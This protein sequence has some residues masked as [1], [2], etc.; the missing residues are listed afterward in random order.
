MHA[1]VCLC[2]CVYVRTYIRGYAFYEMSVFIPDFP[3]CL[4]LCLFAF[5]QL[6]V[7]FL[8]STFVDVCLS[9]DHE[10]LFCR[11]LFVCL[12][13]F[14]PNLTRRL[15]VFAHNHATYA[16]YYYLVSPPGVTCVKSTPLRLLASGES[17]CESITERR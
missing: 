6:S 4:C 9:R 3:M 17:F 5:C 1:C 14:C 13:T 7:C 2:A 15:F 11:C 12:F 10:L 16:G 8:V